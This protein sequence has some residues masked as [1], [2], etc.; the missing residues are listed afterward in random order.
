MSQP[1]AMLFPELELAAMPRP[2][3]EPAATF[4]AMTPLPVELAAVVLLALE[5]AM[6]WLLM[7]LTRATRR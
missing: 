3:V 2:T 1:A 6:L 4:L 7:I 5:L